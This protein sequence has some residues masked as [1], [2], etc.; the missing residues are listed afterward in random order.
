[1]KALKLILFIL[2]IT[3]GCSS[4]PRDFSQIKKDG[5]LRVV[6]AY[7]PLGFY[8]ADDSIVG[9]QHEMI[10]TFCKEV[11]LDCN[12]EVQADLDDCIKDLKDGKY[13]II[14]RLI[15]VTTELKEQVKFTH[16][17]CLDKQV[18]VQRKT[19]SANQ[20]LPLIKSQ[21]ELPGHCISMPKNSP[22]IARLKNLAQEI[23]DTINIEEINNYQSEQLI[24][25]VAKGDLD[26][27]VCNY[28]LAQKIG[29][30]YPQLDYK[31]AIS[32]S[33]MQAWAVSKES[34]ELL[35]VV[36]KWIDNNS[37]KYFK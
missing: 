28:N 31:T 17:I 11:G 25:L 6:M 30:K 24:I 21:L 37:D 19:N 20:P 4:G 2:I 29:E 9:V 36:N 35:E 27:T 10:K 22:Y 16:Q 33:Q 18:L 23:G 1:M 5:E 26:Y 34:E 12:I 15:P 32:F 13:D 7:N 8:R 14:V 3:T